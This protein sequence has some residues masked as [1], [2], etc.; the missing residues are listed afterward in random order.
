MTSVLGVA[1]D[2]LAI[3]MAIGLAAG[4]LDAIA[5]GGGLLTVPALALAGLDPAAAV[6][7][8]K[9]NS[10]LGLTAATATFARRGAYRDAAAWRIAAGS[11]VGALAGALALSSVPTAWLALAMPVVLVAIAIYFALT[12]ALGDKDRAP[13]VSPALAAGF[14]FPLVGFYDGLF[15][16]GAGSFYM[17]VCVALLGRAA[18]AATADTKL[19]NLA[20]AIASLVA[21]ALMG[22]IVWPLGIVMG[23]AQSV[24]SALGARAAMA[25]G[26]RL[27]RPL[28]VL[29]CLAMAIRL[30]ARAGWFG[31]G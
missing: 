5:G 2:L 15:G 18:V 21:Y 17:I 4:F 23:V 13:R 10:T 1:P 26:A 29:A 7:T 16:P 24:G 12:P 30:A 3:M 11:A 20:S 25:G 9:V 22:K 27:I 8:N 31:G 14:F 28:I 6:A 19:C